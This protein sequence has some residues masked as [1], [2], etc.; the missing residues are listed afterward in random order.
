LIKANYGNLKT[1]IEYSKLSIM[2]ISADSP[3]LAADLEA[4]IKWKQR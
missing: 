3:E 2:A 1:A 4:L